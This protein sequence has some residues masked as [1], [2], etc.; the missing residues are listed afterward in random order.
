[1]YVCKYPSDVG[2]CVCICIG[3]GG[4]GVL[5]KVFKKKTTESGF[6]LVFGVG[7]GWRCPQKKKNYTIGPWVQRCNSSM[8]KSYLLGKL[9]KF[10]PL[11]WRT[12]ICPTH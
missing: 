10:V 11:K 9:S 7:W 4:V 12:R 3:G 2:V 5:V 6:C 1:M 8:F